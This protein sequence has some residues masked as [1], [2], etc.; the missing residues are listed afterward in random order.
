MKKHDF[1]KESLEPHRKQKRKIEVISKIE[2]ENID[3]LSTLY[4]PD[5]T[6]YAITDYV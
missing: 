1:N 6:A 5:V 2:V 3:N 4:F